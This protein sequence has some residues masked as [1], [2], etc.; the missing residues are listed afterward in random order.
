MTLSPRLLAVLVCP[1]CKGDL[2]H[3]QQEEAL[4][5]LVCQ[6]RYPIRNE[7][8]IMLTDEATPL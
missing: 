8:P 3:R 2:E 4:D 1:R 6:L 7:I 5:C